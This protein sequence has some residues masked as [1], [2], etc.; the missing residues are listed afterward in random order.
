MESGKWKTESGKWKVGSERETNAN[1][2]VLVNG[3]SL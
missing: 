2:N 3:D 1:L